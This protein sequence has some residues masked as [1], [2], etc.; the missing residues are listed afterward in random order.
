MSEDKQ[1]DT[2]CA[3]C[4]IA[5]IDDVK[6]VPCDGCDLVRYCSDECQNNHKSDHK[7]SCKKR[8]AELRDELLFK[9]PDSTHLG[10]CPICMLP[11]PQGKS[12]THLC[13]S[14]VVCIGCEYAHQKRQYEQRLQLTCPFC[15]EPVART[16]EEQ[17]EQ[18]VKRVEA[19]D[20]VAM[21]ELGIEKRKEGNYSIAFEYL[22]KAAVQG[23]ADAHYRLSYMYYGGQSVEKDKGE[24][25][26]HAE[27]AAIGGH[28]GARLNLGCFEWNNNSNAERSVKHMIIAATQGSDEAIKPLMNAY[29]DGL[30][31]KEDLAAALRAHKDAVDATKSPQ[32]EEAEVYYRAMGFM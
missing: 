12:C 30:V 11:L 16:K 14:K 22:K 21:R 32:R 5:E 4:G 15:R 10:D 18:L 2:S 3:S 23:D 19:N 31:D 1:A 8:A 24:Q 20:P 6:L 9:Q 27:E 29:K 26:Y 17:I 25:I 28:L 7:E 13:C